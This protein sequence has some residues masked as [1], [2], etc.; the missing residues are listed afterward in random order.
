M[1]GIK[2]IE[3]LKDLLN[4]LHETKLDE[5]PDVKDAISHLLRGDPSK[6]K[7]CLQTNPIYMKIIES[8]RIADHIKKNKS[9]IPQPTGKEARDISRG[10]CVIGQVNKYGDELKVNYIDFAGMFLNIGATGSGKSVVVKKILHQACRHPNRSFAILCVDP[11]KREYRGLAENTD[12]T[13]IPY[14]KFMWNPLEIL[15]G[16]TS[17]EHKWILSD[18]LTSQFYLQIISR[19][20]IKAAIEALYRMYDVYNGSDRFPCIPELISAL[21]V[22]QEKAKTK[23][24]KESYERVVNRVENLAEVKA[25]HCRKGFDL[26]LIRKKDI[27]LELGLLESEVK[28]FIVSFIIR[29]LYTVNVKEGL[30]DDKN[31][32][33]LVAIEEARNLLDADRNTSLLGDNSYLVDVPRIRA[34]KVG[35]IITTQEFSSV[36]K[37]VRKNALIKNCFRQSDGEDIDKIAESLGLDEEQKKIFHKLPQFG[38]SIIKHGRHTRPYLL[39]VDPAPIKSNVSDQMLEEIMADRWP[40][41]IDRYEPLN[42][43]EPKTQAKSSSYQLDST[44]NALLFLLAHQNHLSKSQIRK[45]PGFHQLKRLDSAIDKLK[46]HKLIA[47]ESIQVSKTRASIYF[48]LLERAYEYLRIKSPRQGHGSFRHQLF[49]HII[50]RYL[51]GRGYKKVQIEGRFQ[52]GGK[53]IDI[54]AVSPDGVREAYE[55]CLDLDKSSGRQSM[56]DNIVSDFRDGAQVVVVITANDQCTLAEEI[57]LS[58]LGMDLD[59]SGLS[60]KPIKF[61]HTPK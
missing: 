2:D 20:Y 10:E 4:A 5:L 11:E 61:F 24:E 42:Q 17:D 54:K 7:L 46:A 56:I 27:I 35:Q 58:R 38:A 6:L 41:V 23:F 48:P 50:A 14:D 29:Y 22:F 37:E 34:T 51:Q 13:V 1:R 49:Q 30:T 31:L 52:V 28:N 39:K 43:T 60:I 8:N 55:V 32:K 19:R 21:K 25:F 36:A 53:A 47:V 40:F 3:K 33:N 16:L 59:Q 57:I 26:S 44:S 15:P 12:F 9:P 18:T 45:I